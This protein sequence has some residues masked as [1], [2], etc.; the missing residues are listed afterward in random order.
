VAG[1]REQ[2]NEASDSTEDGQFFD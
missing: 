1:C 2:G